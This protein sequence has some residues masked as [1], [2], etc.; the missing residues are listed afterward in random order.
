LSINKSAQIPP[1]QTSSSSSINELKG[2]S[3]VETKDIELRLLHPETKQ[4]IHLPS[5]R[6]RCLRLVAQGKSAKEIAR[7]MNLSTHTINFYLR[8]LREALNCRSTKE[9]ISSYFSSVVEL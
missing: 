8:L 7:E 3:A 1:E 9:L 6:A 4:E 2:L 5:Q